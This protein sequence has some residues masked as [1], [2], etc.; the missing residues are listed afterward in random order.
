V[1][2]G[3]GI[4]FNTRKKSSLMQERVKD[5]FGEYKTNFNELGGKYLFIVSSLPVMAMLGFYMSNI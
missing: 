2:L 5:G 4:N 1:P 3:V